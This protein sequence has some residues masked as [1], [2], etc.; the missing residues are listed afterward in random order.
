MLTL[1]HGM[2]PTSRDTRRFATGAV[3]LGLLACGPRFPT[4]A[5]SPSASSRQVT[6]ENAGVTLA[7]EVTYPAGRGPFPGVVLVHGSGPV[8]RVGNAPLVELFTGLGF[9]VL[10]YDKRGTGASGGGYRGVGPLN[11]DSMLALL[12]GDAMAGARL[13]QAD[14]RIDRDRVGMAG[15][16]QAG[17]VIARAMRDG[18]F[19]FFVALSG[20]TVSVGEEIYFSTL[21]E[22]D[23]SRPLFAADS[24]MALFDGFKGYDPLADLRRG[25]A[26]GLYLFGGRDRSIPVRR[27]LDVLTMVNREFSAA[28]YTVVLYPNADHSLVDTDAGTF[29]PIRDTIAPWLVRA[30][31]LP[32]SPRR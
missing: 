22:H 7:G 28:R 19:R 17:W 15:G 3:W 10:A 18:T 23:L 12:G 6:F 25:S 24:L 9:A 32:A 27:S 21:F 29:L 4:A 30:G 2:L 5:Q 16:S 14:A 13:L 1:L 31:L 8:T 26:I 20:P 11:S